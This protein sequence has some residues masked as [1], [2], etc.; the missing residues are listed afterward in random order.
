M[1]AGNL[2][3]QAGAVPGCFDSA[4]AALVDHCRGLPGSQRARE[5]DHCLARAHS[6]HGDAVCVSEASEE[7]LTSVTRLHPTGRCEVNHNLYSE[8]S[9][10]RFSISS[11]GMQ[12]RKALACTVYSCLD[13]EHSNPYEHK[14]PCA[15]GT[16]NK[17]HH[18]ENSIPRFRF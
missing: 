12:A 8:G 13:R 5:V 2:R 15:E 4:G 18:V 6:H 16:P 14:G 3:P 10:P 9:F 1:G 7:L 17:V 11:W